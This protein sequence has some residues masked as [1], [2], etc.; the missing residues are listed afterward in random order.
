MT[1]L[2][3][4]GNAQINHGRHLLDKEAIRAKF[5]RLLELMEGEARPDLY[6]V[7]IDSLLALAENGTDALDMKI[8]T[9]ALREM[10]EAFATFKPYSGIRKVTFFG[11][12][13]TRADD[14]LYSHARALAGRMASLGWM[15]VT[16]A[17]PGIMRAAMEGAGIDMSLGVNIRLPHE[18]GANSLIANDP[19]LVEMRY[20]F[21]RKLM[22]VKESDAYVVLPGGFGTLDESFELFTL[23]QTGKME[24]APVVLLDVPGGSY[25]NEWNDLISNVLVPLAMVNQEDTSL[26]TITTSIDSA[27]DEITRFYSNYHSLRFVGDMLVI[28]LHRQPTSNQLAALADEFSDIAVDGIIRTATPFPPERADNDH[29]ELRRIALRFNKSSYGRLRLMVD[30]INSF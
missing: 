8:A 22:L 13:R 21:T 10:S 1:P 5:E 29:L 15:T 27:I 6:A 7:A 18:Q 4:N 26:F 23:L 16:G 11:S 14:A 3:A 2:V 12:S 25:W 17:G 20:F 28:R 24:P 9:S 30:R 19:K